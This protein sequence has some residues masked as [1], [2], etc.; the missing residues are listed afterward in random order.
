MN[1]TSSA[2]LI[3]DLG[4]D[5][6]LGLVFGPEFLVANTNGWYAK[7][8]IAPNITTFR[9]MVSSG[10]IYSK[11]WLLRTLIDV[12]PQHRASWKIAVTGSWLGSLVWG[13]A[14]C[15]PQAEVTGIDFDGY[16]IEYCN[17]VYN[18]PQFKF[19]NQDMYDHDWQTESYDIVVNTAC[20]H[21]A[22]LQGWLDDIPSGTIVV[23][24]SNNLFDIPEHIACSHTLEQFME[25]MALS[26]YLYSDALQFPM[27]T[28]FMVIGKV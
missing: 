23:L 13:L 2:Q 8:Q 3:A 20:E 10:Q 5:P 17:Q 16:C 9:D 28:R 25:R 18:G 22:Y 7:P 26:T 1:A 27:Y 21:I 6:H 19:V 24:Q 4:Q 15:F 14:K 12:L 11:L